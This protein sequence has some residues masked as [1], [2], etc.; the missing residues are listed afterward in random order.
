MILKPSITVLDLPEAGAIEHEI[1]RKIDKLGKF[2]PHLMSCD[3]VLRQEQKQQHQGK[4][5]RPSITVGVP[6]DKINVNH[7]ANEDAYVAVR[8]AFNALQ[9]QLR[10]YASRQR[11]DVKL[12]AL[13][14]RGRIAR[15]FE[16]EGFGFIESGDE[17]FYF[18]SFNVSNTDFERLRVGM[19]VSFIEDDTASGLQAK[20]VN[21]IKRRK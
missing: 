11:G 16:D 1:L 17:E 9:R 10:D 13:P 19:S 14:L 6:G 21:L 15:L 7:A 20:R 3:V 8:D 5:Y 12:H 4:L 2:Y 18:S